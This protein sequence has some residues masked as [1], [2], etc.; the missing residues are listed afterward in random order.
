MFS[1]LNTISIHYIYVLVYKGCWIFR[2]TLLL[3]IKEIA[4]ITSSHSGTLHVAM[5]IY[6]SIYLHVH[7]SIYL[8]RWGKSG[9]MS[10]ILIKTEVSCALMGSKKLNKLLSPFFSKP[11]NLLL[12]VS[13]RMWP[14]ATSLQLS[15]PSLLL[16]FWRLW[17]IPFPITTSVII[18]Q[19]SYN[20]KM[21]LSS[22]SPA[23]LYIYGAHP[24]HEVP[25]ITPNPTKTTSVISQKGSKSIVANLPTVFSWYVVAGVCLRGRCF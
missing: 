4:N 2:P 1:I 13:S 19:H 17:H 10:S 24:L 9:H 16:P 21:P 22:S 11:S 12:A 20:F 5:Y 23:S 6:L 25:I 15:S 8:S 14:F 3:D 18:E 7:L